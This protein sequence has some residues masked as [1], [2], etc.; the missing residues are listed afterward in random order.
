MSNARIVQLEKRGVVIGD[1]TAGVMQSLG[2]RHFLG[3]DSGVFY[4]ANIT[5]ADVIMTDGKSLERVGVTPD[6]LLLQ[7]AA[8]LAAGRDPVLAR[9]AAIAGFELPPDKA[10]A[11]FPIEWRK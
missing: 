10:G 11:M 6:E 7:T 8:D 3:E 9:A 2:F 5:N 1:R 4:G